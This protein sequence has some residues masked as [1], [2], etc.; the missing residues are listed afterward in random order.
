[1]I[2]SWNRDR[3]RLEREVCRP[4]YAPLLA[5]LQQGAP[6]VAQLTNWICVARFVQGCGIRSA[7]ADCVVRPLILGTATVGDSRPSTIL[8][9]LFLPSLIRLHRQRRRWL[10]C[11]EERWAMI[12]EC[13]VR[14]VRRLDPARRPERLGQKLLNDTARRLYDECARDWA[15]EARTDVVD[16]IDL[17]ALLG[18]DDPGF[19]E[20][21]R[22]EACNAAIRRVRSAAAAGVISANDSYL[23]LGTR[24]Y[25]ADLR[26]AAGQL[27][28]PYER[29]KKRRQRAEATLGRKIL[30]RDP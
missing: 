21:E 24:I 6:E 12:C 10:P 25:G 13:F 28:I 7:A 4:A 20:V 5:D 19:Q 29:A 2:A 1:V 26:D 16:P 15:R 9:L 17:E 30:R 23:V 18:V 22:R 8:L 27:G 11:E 3:A 14:A